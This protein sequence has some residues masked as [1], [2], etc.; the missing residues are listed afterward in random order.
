MTKTYKCY[1]C[2]FTTQ[3][4]YNIESH[5]K[6]KNIC[7]KNDECTYSD[8]E[9][10][11]LN[12]NQF[13]NTNTNKFEKCTFIKCNDNVINNTI[14]NTINNIT[15]VTNNLTLNIDNLIP[16]DED[17]DLSQI[18][19]HE[20]VLILF[21]RIMYTTFLEKILENDNNSN[22]ILD[23]DNNCGLVYTNQDNNEK[24]YILMEWD[25][26]LKK[27]MDKLNKQLKDIYNDF[28]NDLLNH[29]VADE[30]KKNIDEKFNNFKAKKD[31]HNLVEKYVK[32]IYE[33]NKDK[34]VKMLRVINNSKRDDSNI[35]GY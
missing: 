24:K 29:Y 35:C 10:E 31:I 14:N 15:N 16:F 25:N 21:S 20:K 22:I 27:S 4:K 30:C 12:N 19:K 32:D 6:I 34:S 18:A 8:S 9:I 28:E 13:I 3:K 11:D 7:K 2:F 33:N 5:F 23:G 1:R 26:I 17:W